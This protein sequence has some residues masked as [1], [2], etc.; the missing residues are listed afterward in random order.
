MLAVCG[1]RTA[2]AAS[3]QVGLYLY[4]KHVLMHG[5][6]AAC[7]SLASCMSH[8]VCSAQHVI[9]SNSFVTCML[10]VPPRH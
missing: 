3:Q 5:M 7:R 1:K 8:T 2:Q 4:T 6:L 9:C 10:A